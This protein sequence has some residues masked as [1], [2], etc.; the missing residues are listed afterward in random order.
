MPIVTD[1]TTIVEI[2]DRISRH[3]INLERPAL[4]HKVKDKWVGITYRELRDT[5]RSFAMG[6][7]ALGLKRGD[8][9]GIISENRPEW[10]FSDLA[11]LSIGAVDVPM[12]PSS[13][14]NTIEYIMNDSECKAVIV[15]N[16][17]QLTKVQ[18]IQSNVKSL[19]HIIIMNE[20]D[21]E[22]GILTFNQVVELGKKKLTSLSQFLMKK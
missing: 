17:L 10:V 15:S 13:T 4:M 19:K 11:I 20:K 18:K 16:K 22:E 2:Y 1:F 8:M 14:S 21:A 7:L 6:L 5:V 9:V 3:F 12:Y